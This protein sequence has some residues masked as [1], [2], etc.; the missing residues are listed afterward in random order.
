MKSLWQ[1]L[2]VGS[3]S[4]SI[5]AVALDVAESVSKLPPGVA[6]SLSSGSAGIALFHAYLDRAVPDRGFGETAG[7]FISDAYLR[8]PQCRHVPGLYGGWTGVG[9]AVE[10]LSKMYESSSDDGDD[11]L[12]ELDDR[13][14]AFLR[15][16]S[17]LPQEYDLVGGYV[18]MGVYALERLPRER[19]IE[20]L[21]LIVHHLDRLGHN[22]GEGMSWHHS[23]DLLPVWTRPNFPTGWFNLGLAHGMPGIVGLLCQLIAA[24]IETERTQEMLGLLLRWILAQRLP[25]NANRYFPSIIGERGPTQTNRS[26]WCY[27]DPGVAITLFSAGTA[28]KDRSL[29][30]LAI[31]MMQHVA[32]REK[33]AHGVRDPMLCH[34]AIGLAHLYNR[35]YQATRLEQFADDARHWVLETLAYRTDSGFG[36]FRSYLPTPETGTQQTSDEHWRVDPGFLTGS[37]GL[38]LGLLAACTDCEPCWDRILLCSI[39][40]VSSPGTT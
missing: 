6:P 34:G 21:T 4:E 7:G 19:A 26:A 5:L 35:F 24:N 33:A 14:V 15:R 28:V 32:C 36:G 37:T 31:E 1:P 25:I 10:H 8:L 11:P 2:F 27:G 13:L 40:P 39:R 22:K 12:D 20:A 18:G 38:A 23:V 30:K 16:P 3:Q 9:F 17:N 29:E